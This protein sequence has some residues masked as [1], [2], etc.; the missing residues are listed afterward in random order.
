M[1]KQVPSEAH[2]SDTQL[3]KPWECANL[4][5]GQSA[6]TSSLEDTG[7]KSR[8]SELGPHGHGGIVKLCH[9]DRCL[10]RL[11]SAQEDPVDDYYTLSFISNDN[12]K[13]SGQ[14]PTE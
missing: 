12:E 11:K 14:L 8:I 13:Y 6:L 4:K 1:S 3:P 2:L 9:I 7:F 10:R 5:M